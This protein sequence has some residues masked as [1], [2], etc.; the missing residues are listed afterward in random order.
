MTTSIREGDMTWE[1]FATALGSMGAGGVLG[2]IVDRVFLRRSNRADVLD[3]LETIAGRIA[4]RAM[5][6]ADKRVEQ[7]EQKVEVA[8][9][10]V[11][12]VET[13]LREHQ[14]RRRVAAA[15][16][17]AWDRDVAQKLTDLGQPVGPPPSLE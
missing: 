1:Q 11:E 4:D 7:A 16:H 17:A 8:E 6:Q 3:K 5:E 15:R 10:K 12:Q 14:E 2:G 9:Q 13:K